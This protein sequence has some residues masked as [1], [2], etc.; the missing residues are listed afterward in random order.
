MKRK[1]IGWIIVPILI[2]LLFFS[3][4]QSFKT[5]ADVVNFLLRQ[6]GVTIDFKGQDGIGGKS[7]NAFATL[8]KPMSE[9]L[10]IT[11][12]RLFGLGITGGYA[13]QGGLMYNIVSLPIE[14]CF[15]PPGKDASEGSEGNDPFSNKFRPWVPEF[16]TSRFLIPIVGTGLV[17]IF[18]LFGWRK[19][20][21]QPA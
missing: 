19:P 15:P 20:A 4:G 9:M 1:K 3:Q 18:I 7:C 17:M 11:P 5:S 8:P 14:F 12:D 2:G 6:E 21:K 16:A 10:G 13:V